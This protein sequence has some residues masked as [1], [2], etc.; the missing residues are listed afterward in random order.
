[1]KTNSIH[2]NLFWTV[3]TICLILLGQLL[4][5]GIANLIKHDWKD[6]TEKPW[7]C[8]R[9]HTTT[10]ESYVVIKGKPVSINREQS[11]CDEWRKEL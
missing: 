4:G 2:P 7:T 6:T 9:E 10:V 8:Y 1:M 3:A 11:V 5:D